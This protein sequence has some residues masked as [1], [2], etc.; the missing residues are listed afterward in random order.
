VQWEAKVLDENLKVGVTQPVTGRGTRAQAEYRI[1]QR[2][3]ARASWD[4]Q[5]QNTTIGNPGI[6]LRFLF[7]WE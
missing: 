7:E 6:D 4:N 2:V 3:S 1:N 5:N